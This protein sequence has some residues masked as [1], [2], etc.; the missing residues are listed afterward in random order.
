MEKNK[1]IITAISLMLLSSMVVFADSLDIEVNPMD[2]TIMPGNTGYTTATVTPHQVKPLLIKNII[3]KDTNS[4]GI[5]DDFLSNPCSEVSVVF[6]ETGNNETTTDT[7]G[8]AIIK[9]MLGSN[10]T[11]GAKYMYYVK[12]NDVGDWEDASVIAQ[13]TGGIPEFS[14]MAIPFFMTLA[15]IGLFLRKKPVTNF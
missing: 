4:N 12:T 3:C 13:A 2:I 6:N 8:E 1:I 10:A 14:T 5:C 11:A 15:S 9:I 7:N